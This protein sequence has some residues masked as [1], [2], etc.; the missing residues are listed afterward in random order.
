MPKYVIEAEIEDLK[1]IVTKFAEFLEAYNS[2]EM[3]DEYE[4]WNSLE[5]STLKAIRILVGAEKVD[6]K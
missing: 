5:Q 2:E 4:D 1:K 6:S 3:F